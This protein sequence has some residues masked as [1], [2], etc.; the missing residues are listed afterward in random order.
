MFRTEGTAELTEVYAE[1]FGLEK[2][3]GASGTTRGPCYSGDTRWA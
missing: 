2:T 1:A 3:R